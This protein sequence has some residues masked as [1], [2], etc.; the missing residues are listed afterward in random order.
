MRQA[1]RRLKALLQRTVAL[2]AVSTQDN[3]SWPG[4]PAARLQ[5][6]WTGQGLERAGDPSGSLA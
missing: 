6:G 3:L 4:Q 1:T 2:A 5:H